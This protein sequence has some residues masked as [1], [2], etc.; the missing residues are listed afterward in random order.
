MHPEPLHRLVFFVQ[1]FQHQGN[2]MWPVPVP[3]LAIDFEPLLSNVVDA[4]R[5]DLTKAVVLK[6][7]AVNKEKLT[8]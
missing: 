8:V 1:P 4:K 7:T 6:P 2:S 3:R 5:T